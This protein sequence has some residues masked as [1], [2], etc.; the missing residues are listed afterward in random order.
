MFGRIIVATD[1]TASTSSS[2]GAACDL[3]HSEGSVMLVHV[4]RSI[5][6]VPEAELRKVY[7][8]LKADAGKRMLELK[9]GFTRE[10]GVDIL[11]TTV[12]GSPGQEIARIAKEWDA[13]LI[14][15][16]HDAADDPA[17]LGSVSYRVAHLAPCAVLMLKAP[18]HVKTAGLR[19]TRAARP[20]PQAKRRAPAPSRGDRRVS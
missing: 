1:L 4:V 5:V 13:D 11:C 7:A 8:Q 16:A 12:I 17:V 2:L 10:R 15:L 20:V 18:Q 19:P 6:G 3:C 14:V 9:A